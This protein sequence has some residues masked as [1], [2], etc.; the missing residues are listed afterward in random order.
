LADTDSHLQQALRDRYVLERELGRG[1]MATVYLARDLRHDRPVALKV[2]HPELATSLGPERFLREVKLAARLQH[3]HILS[4]HDSGE[5][6]G[7]LWFTMPY[8]EG[9]SLRDRLRRERELPLG[10]A[11]QIT[12]E[13]AQ[14]LDYAH[15]HGVI[16]RDI[17]PENILLTRDGNVLVA[18]FGIARALASGAEEKLTETGLSLGTPAYMS[19]EQAAGER[20]IDAR[21]D[22]YSLACVLYEM[23]AGEPPFT[24]PTAQA[25]IAK[26]FSTAA[27]PVR[28]LRPDVPEP[29]EQAL[30]KALARMPAGRFAGTGEFA[31]AL[32]LPE[33]PSS[34]RQTRWVA[35]TAA[36]IIGIVLLAA[37]TWTFLDR[38]PDSRL[39]TGDSLTTRNSP[40]STR[41]AVLPF[42]NLGDT[43]DA[44]FADGMTDEIRGK[45][46]SVHGLEVIA[47]TTSERYR[48]ATNNP[49][50]IG[51]ELGV[52]YLL[53][54][55]VRWAKRG[56]GPS[57]VRVSPELVRASS[58]TTTWQEPF[59]AA[60]TDVFQVQADIAERVAGALHLALGDSAL[61]ALAER[62]TSD[63]AAYTLYLRGRYHWNTRTEKG[64][65]QAVRD[66]R[67]AIE[68]D[69]AYALAYTGLADA[70]LNLADF[71]LLPAAE[72]ILRAQAAAERALALDGMQAEAHAS[73]GGVREAQRDWRGAERE[74]RR[75][76]ALKEVYPTAHHW[77]SLLL[78]KFPGR[79]TEALRESRRALALDPLSVPINSDVGSILFYDGQYDAAIEQF[80]RTLD[81][82]PAFP[83][84][85]DELGLA[86]SAKGRYTEGIGA[87]RKA[88]EVVPGNPQLLADLG[89]IYARAGQR[90]PAMAILAK[91]KRTRDSTR[92]AGYVGMLYGAL[93]ERD[94][95]FHW[96]EKAAWDIRSSI[97]IPSDLRLAPLRSDTRYL[98]LMRKLG[99]L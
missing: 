91:L 13:A 79:M 1:G 6:A 9:E 87:L 53:T 59:E 74:Y 72:A 23:L 25:I 92:I 70:Y 93:G 75:A 2:L 60:L 11:V 15:Q 27:T 85:L 97:F 51:R 24:G 36:L 18:D 41:L 77:Y 17:K 82:E 16:H 56:P 84:A 50:Q 14:A 10:D 67:Q 66:F 46:A 21:T 52:Q 89:Y 43:A 54:G 58:G 86:Y 4:V 44:Y 37:V 88:L 73:L 48:P 61:R 45:L 29:I 40:E 20:T 12:R 64:L 65:N 42:D 80:R 39:A 7:R 57:R 5:A 90:E 34:L 26:R 71:Y 32:E 31:R 47:R 98:Q 69:S 99:L 63:L 78:L 22:V 55:T 3:P 8:V 62:P 28:V 33:T 81:L 38:R 49:Q 19:P 68:R 95:A 83:W 94:S 30:S 96:L 35:R 76:I